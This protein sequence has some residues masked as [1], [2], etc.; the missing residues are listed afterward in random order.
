MNRKLR[1][2]LNNFDKAA[3][4][5]DCVEILSEKNVKRARRFL[6]TFPEYSVTPLRRL[7]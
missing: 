3:Q 1:M 5:S 2:V 4:P 7:E 6:A